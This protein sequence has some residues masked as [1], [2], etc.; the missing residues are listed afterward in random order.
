MHASPP[1]AAR[2]QPWVCAHGAYGGLTSHG[3]TVPLQ[4]PAGVQVVMPFVQQLTAG[5]RHDAR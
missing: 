1:S 2:Q 3:I 5:A 4:A